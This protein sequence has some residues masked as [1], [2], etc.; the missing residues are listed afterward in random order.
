MAE[1]YGETEVRSVVWHLDLCDDGDDGVCEQRKL[2][3]REG[4]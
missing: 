2:F 3:V 1:Y 4:K